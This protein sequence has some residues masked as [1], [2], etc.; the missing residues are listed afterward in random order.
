MGKAVASQHP[1]VVLRS[2]YTLVRALL[3]AAIVAVV[4]LT[5]AVVILATDEDELSSATSRPIESI[6]YGGFNPATGRPESA[7][8]PQRESQ[9]PSGT[10]LERELQKFGLTPE[11]AVKEALPGVNRWGGPEEGTRGPVGSAQGATSPLVSRIGGVASTGGAAGE[12]T[13]VAPPPSSIAASDAS[14]YSQLRRAGA[15]TTGPSTERYDG[16]PE[17]GT[18]GAGH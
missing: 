2:H 9:G 18:R 5:V 3:A 16:G 11:Q 14:A 7:P 10:T 1:A 15:R 12:A 17:E 4:G 13:R 6:S 8:L